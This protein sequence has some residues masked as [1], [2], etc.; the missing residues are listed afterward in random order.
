M[1]PRSRMAIEGSQV[2]W[3]IT[4]RCRDVTEDVAMLRAISDDRIRRAIEGVTADIEC[5]L[6]AIEA[7]RQK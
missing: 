3:R 4:W 1:A 2:T 5:Q 6:A 7:A